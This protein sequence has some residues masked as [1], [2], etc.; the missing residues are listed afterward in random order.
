M[1]R[2]QRGN[3]DIFNKAMPFAVYFP[4]LPITFTAS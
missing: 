4:G 2:V 3:M 1:A